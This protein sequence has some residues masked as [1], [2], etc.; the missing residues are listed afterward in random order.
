MTRADMRAGVRCSQRYILWD[1]WSYLLL[2][3][4]KCQL[5]VRVQFWS[6]RFETM[7]SNL[8]SIGEEWEWSGAREM[9]KDVQ[10]QG[11]LVWKRIYTEGRPSSFYPSRLFFFSA[12]REDSAE[13]FN[14]SSWENSKL[15]PSMNY[16]HSWEN[17]F[18]S[19]ISGILPFAHRGECCR[20]LSWQVCWTS[21]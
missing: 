18:L 4:G 7:V 11:C 9:R 19:N 5:K 21:S 13:L 2:V 17:R 6:L 15:F 16:L 10:N 12:A 3:S 14:Y 8:E 20:D 1:L